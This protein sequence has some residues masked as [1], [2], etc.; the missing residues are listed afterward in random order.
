MGSWQ[1]MV[2]EHGVDAVVAEATVRFLKP[3][4]FDEEIELVTT[5]AELGTTSMRIAIAL[6]REGEVCAEGENRYV[7][8]DPGA[9]GKTPIPDGVREALSK[10][11]P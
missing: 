10:F 2:D 7:V 5:V 3:L 1:A 9:G 6:E 11:S 8:I 4:R